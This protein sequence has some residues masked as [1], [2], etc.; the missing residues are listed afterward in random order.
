MELDFMK[1]LYVFIPC[2]GGG[3]VQ[4]TT[5]FGSG[6]FVMLFFPYFLPLLKSSAL[7]SLFSLCPCMMLAWRFRAHIRPKVV[8]LPAIFYLTFSALAIRFAANTDLTQ[9]KAFFGLFLIIISLYFIFFADKLRIK[10]N[11]LTAFICGSIS[12]VASG[13]FGIGGPPMVIYML[14]IAGDDKEAYL[15]NTQFFFC[16]TGIYTAFLRV[17]N[18]ILTPDLLP[19]V[20]PGMIGMTIGKNVGV[21]IVEKIDVKLMKK[22]IYAFLGL[23]GLL[24]FVTNI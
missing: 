7:S 21:N 5:G 15:A 11:L 23:S 24:T 8:V 12:G 17:V 1:M 13:L 14:G 6:I 9:L 10:P 19:L 20:I 22:L 16:L 18:G 4:G 3:L 2:I